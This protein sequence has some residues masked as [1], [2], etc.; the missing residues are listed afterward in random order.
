M[1]SHLVRISLRLTTFNSNI[2]YL[3]SWA[4]LANLSIIEKIFDENVI[5]IYFVYFLGYLPSFLTDIIS[6]KNTN[7][8]S[9]YIR[10]IYIRS[11][12]IVSSCTK[13]L[14]IRNIYAG[15]AFTC[16]G[17]T[18]TK[19]TCIRV[20]GIKN[21]CVRDAGIVKCLEIHF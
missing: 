17:G 7:I 18:C 15:S 1:S 2:V 5:L 12:S 8:D 11:T 10:D 14:L 16:T 9:L 21:I 13:S 4:N 20:T 6:T 3:D 19:N